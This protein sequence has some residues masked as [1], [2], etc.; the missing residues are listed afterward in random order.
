M[1]ISRS[2][3]DPDTLENLHFTTVKRIF[4]IKRGLSCKGALLGDLGPS[5]ARFWRPWARMG[6]SCGAFKA[7]RWQLRLP[8]IPPNVDKS[9]SMN[10]T[11]IF[12]ESAFSHRKIAV[13]EGEGGNPDFRNFLGR[14][15]YTV[16]YDGL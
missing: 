6:C 1:P 11:W 3:A 4:L 8:R 2:Q 9:N 7:S 13:F 10:Q 5:W 16:I 12:K 14:P 15:P